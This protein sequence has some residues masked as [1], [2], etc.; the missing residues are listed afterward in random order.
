MITEVVVEF[1]EFVDKDETIMLYF[2]YAQGESPHIKLWLGKDL[3]LTRVK[4][5]RGFVRDMRKAFKLANLILDGKI[6]EGIPLKKDL[7]K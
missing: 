2:I 5:N 6:R 3:S 4:A 7:D 1:V